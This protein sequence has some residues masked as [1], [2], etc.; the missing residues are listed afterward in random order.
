MGFILSSL[1]HISQR[2]KTRNIRRITQKTGTSCGVACVAMLS[3][4]S[5]RDAFRVGVACFGK[6]AWD[7][8]HRTDA[9]DLRVM[10][11]ALGWRLGREVKCKA[12]RKIPARA[13]VAVQKKPKKGWHWVVS[14]CDSN[15]PFFFDPRKSVKAVRRREFKT[16]PVFWYHRV[17]QL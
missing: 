1:R 16:V 3:R 5:Y 2:R 4:I 6:A 8:S 9:S 11:A 17:C 15:G 10:L 13:L 7:E 14:D 12:W